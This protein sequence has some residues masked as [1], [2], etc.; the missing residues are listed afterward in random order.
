MAKKSV[1]VLGAGFGGL[2]AAIDSAKSLRRLKLL[3]RYEV[4]LV[5]RNDCHLYVPLLYKFAASNDDEYEK[6]CTYEITDLIKGLPIRFVNAE[7]ASVDLPNGI[8]TFKAG[9]NIAANLRADYLIMALGSETNF[10]GIPGMQENALQL[11]TLESALQIRAAITKAFA[12]G[13]QSGASETKIV[14]GGGG[15]NGI[16]LASEIRLWANRVEKENSNLHVSVSIVEAMPGMLNGLDARGAKIA[17]R[18]LKQL[19]ID[20]KTN[21]KI[22]AVSANE[23]A[24]A[25][26]A[27]MPFDVFVWT[28]GVKTPDLLNTLPIAKDQRGKPLAKN[29]MACVAGTPDLKLAPM[30]YG[31]GDSVC[32]MDPRTGRAV[33]A[34]AHVAILEGKIAARNVVAEIKRTELGGHEFLASTY[35]PGDYPWV[36]PVG[37][38][39][40]IAKLGPLVF[41]GW[42]GWEFSRLVE[43][44]YLISIMS[45]GRAWSTWRRM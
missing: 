24:I 38:N 37:E 19:G 32:F 8:I 1:V 21:M 42:F 4:V 7:V 12:K 20:V 28:G 6:K 27:P 35:R 18:R 14:I 17:V 13:G 39:W 22:T 25:G 33:P 43:L 40:A 5:D 36:I 3:D 9:T 2:R 10:F 34:V 41:A 30:V 45:P 26:A 29:D 15:P 31:I 11:K 44:N 16:E 23:I